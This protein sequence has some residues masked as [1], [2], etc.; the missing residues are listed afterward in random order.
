MHHGSLYGRLHN[1]DKTLK[2]LENVDFCAKFNQEI[3]IKTVNLTYIFKNEE[4]CNIE[5]VK[6]RCQA[7]FQEALN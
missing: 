7:M 1:K 4:K 2:N 6:L 3:S 5:E